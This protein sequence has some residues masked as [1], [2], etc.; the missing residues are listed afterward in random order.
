MLLHLFDLIF[1][2]LSTVV[3]PFAWVFFDFLLDLPPAFFAAVFVVVFAIRDLWAE[4]AS[5]MVIMN[6]WMFKNPVN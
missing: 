5:R 1:A 2:D 3:L 4:A 6:V